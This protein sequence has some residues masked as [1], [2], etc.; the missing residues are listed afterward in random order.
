MGNTASIEFEP[1]TGCIGARVHG[2]DLGVVLG[3]DDFDVLVAG[4]MEHLILVFAQQD[5]SPAQHVD[6][7][8]R[9][10]ALEPRH[11]LYP[12]VDNLENIMLIE[13]GPERP[14]DNETWHAD[15]TFRPA[16]CHVSLLQAKVLP[17]KGGD[18]MFASMYAVYDDLSAP[19]Q[20]FLG[21][22]SAV[23][24]VECGFRA[25]IVNRGEGER[26]DA[27]DHMDRASAQA[28][29]P[30]IASHPVTGRR[31]INVNECF[32]SHIVELSSHESRDVLAGLYAMV[33]E[34]RYQVRHRWCVNDLAVWDNLAT[35]HFAVGDYSQYRAMH[36]VTVKHVDW[37]FPCI[38]AA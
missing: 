22:L 17:P 31:F 19:L 6:L 38:D 4:L 23:H 8:R 25:D 14:P 37:R 26:L 27:L 2:V 1:L 28:C 34:P 33:R 11:P 18:T 32:T 13:N 3:D 21:D 35:Q 12:I 15:M 10:G 36:R 7:G 5:I 24:D 16:P 20:A 9:F 29:H 30:V